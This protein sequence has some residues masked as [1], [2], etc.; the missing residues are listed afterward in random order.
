M[1]TVQLSIVIVSWNTRDMLMDCLLSVYSQLGDLKTEVIVVD[2]ASSDDSNVMLNRRF[3]Q[4][5]LIENTIN[6]GF[7]AANNQAIKIARGKYILLLNSDTLIL[8]NVLMRSIEYMERMNLS[9]L[10]GVGCLIWM[11]LFSGLVV[12]SPLYS[13]LFC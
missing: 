7:A 3:P 11:A 6:M 2:N 13:I 1:E 8:G 4:V 9:V 12:A 5:K 10:W